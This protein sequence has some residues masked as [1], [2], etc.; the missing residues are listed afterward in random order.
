METVKIKIDPNNID[1]KLVKMAGE[2]LKG[3]GVVAFPTETV[4]GL[5]AS[6]FDADAVKRVFKAKG[7]PQDNPLILHV[8]DIGDVEKIAFLNH[9]A[10]L[11]FER[12]S[13]GPITVIMNKKSCVPDIITAGLETVA[14][15]IPSH[16]VAAAVIAAAGVP[17]AAPSANLSGTPSTT[18]AAHVTTDLDG[19]IDMIV[20]GGDCTV[21][22]ESTVVDTTGD[23]PVVLRPGGVSTEEIKLVT[24]E[25]IIGGVLKEDIAPKSPGMKYRHYAPAAEVVVFEGEVGEV[26]NKTNAAVEKYIAEGKK[27]AVIAAADSGKYN[28]EFICAGKSAGIYAHNLFDALRRLD[29]G[30]ADVIIAQIIWKGGISEAIRNRLYKAAHK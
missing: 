20:D 6:G 10:R 12:F 19:K 29:D 9:N 16:R 22:L 3:G 25:V 30:G 1:E 2:C 26:Y 28:C 4:Y 24:G 23:I 18:T 11:L 8:A 5:G 17:V 21:G 13:P 27:A 14:V 15:R 7:R